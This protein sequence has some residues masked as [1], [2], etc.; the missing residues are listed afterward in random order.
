[1]VISSG[2]HHV[3]DQKSQKGYGL[4]TSED[5]ADKE[6]VFITPAG[7]HFFST[8]YTAQPK[9]C[10]YYFCIQPLNDF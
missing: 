8:P 10:R 9:K 1:M 5:P 6:P 4:K 7:Y 2:N 3:N